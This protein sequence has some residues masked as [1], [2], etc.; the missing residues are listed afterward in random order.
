MKNFIYFIIVFFCLSSYSSPMPLGL[1]L[2]KTTALD[3]A[4]KYKI[5]LKEMNYWRGYNYFIDVNDIKAENVS[6]ALVICNDFSVVEAV[7]LSIDNNKFEEL[8]DI[9]KNKYSLVD[10][11]KDH[12][13]T[14][15]VTF[16][17]DNCLVILESYELNPKLE[18]V[19]ITNNFYKDFLNKLDKE[20]KLKQG[21]IKELL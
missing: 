20:E 7:M 15:T 16:S 1:E 10:N 9:L 17:D 6:K 18:L 3:L 21:Q 2:S 5:T 14:R 12:E 4:K 13:G 11:L 19:Y 8:Y